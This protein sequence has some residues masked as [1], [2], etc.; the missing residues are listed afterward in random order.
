ML[1]LELMRQ[2][3]NWAIVTVIAGFGF[4]AMATIFPE[5]FMQQKGT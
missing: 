1:N 2:P 4:L 5:F 3:L